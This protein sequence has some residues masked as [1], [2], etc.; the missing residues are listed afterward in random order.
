MASHE[1]TS[2]GMSNEGR[3]DEN[4][5]CN[6]GRVSFH[7]CLYISCIVHDPVNA[8]EIALIDVLIA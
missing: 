3:M 7:L 8:I 1:R 6:D 5:E 2:G 4:M